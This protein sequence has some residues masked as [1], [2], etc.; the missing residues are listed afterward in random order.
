M[1]AEQWFSLYCKSNTVRVHDRLSSR[2]VYCVLT[3]KDEVHLRSEFQLLAAQ[4]RPVFPEGSAQST[5][6]ECPLDEAGLLVE[7]G[8]FSRRLV[9][10]GSHWVLLEVNLLPDMKYVHPK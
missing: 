9:I 6:V 4:Q 8:L 10:C 5:E 1:L 3:A 7:G 2:V